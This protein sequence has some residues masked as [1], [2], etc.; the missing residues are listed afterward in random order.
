[1]SEANRISVSIQDVWAKLN[2]KWTGEDANAFYREYLL[3]LT[4][5][6]DSFEDACIG[7][8]AQS[9]ALLKELQDIERSIAEQ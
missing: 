7:L 4:E 5:I 6:A 1:M 2:T 8:K 9:L 3:K